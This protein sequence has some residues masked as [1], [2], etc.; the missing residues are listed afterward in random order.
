MA[1]LDSMLKAEVSFANK[2]R[3]VKATVFLVV[4]YG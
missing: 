4:M 1:N 3:A 2:G